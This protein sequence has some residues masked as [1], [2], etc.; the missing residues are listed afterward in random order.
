MPGTGEVLSLE[1][2]IRAALSDCL[3]PVRRIPEHLKAWD[4]TQGDQLHEFGKQRGGGPVK[5]C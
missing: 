3:L 5:T 4:P 2:L 1:L